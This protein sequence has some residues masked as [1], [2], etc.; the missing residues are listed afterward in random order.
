MASQPDSAIP[1]TPSLPKKTLIYVFKGINKLIPWHKL[2]SYIGVLNL[3]A[4]RYELRQHN[5]HDV[6]PAPSYQ[7]TLNSPPMPSD[8]AHTRNSD[9]L[10]NDVNQPKMGCIGM[11]LGR[12]VP[13]EW[14]TKPSVD[15]MMTPNPRVVSQVLLKRDEFKPATILNL[16]AAA[17]I[18]F[19]VHDW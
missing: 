15:E 17:W 13:R 5:L 19:Q 8:F 12:N 10:F 14:T 11:R 9:G 16:L 4:Y 6:Y 3:A 7:G 2:P 1:Y 18:Q